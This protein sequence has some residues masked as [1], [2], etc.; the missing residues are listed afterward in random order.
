MAAAL[1]HARR[2]S[3]SVG[4]NSLA[5]ASGGYC[6]A[7]GGIYPQSY[8]FLLAANFAALECA[9][10]SLRS[11]DAAGLENAPPARFIE[12]HCNCD[13]DYRPTIAFRST[14]G[15]FSHPFLRDFCAAGALVV[16]GRLSAQCGPL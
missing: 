1:S 5:P 8:L 6:A 13:R 11:G 14:H 9:E 2:V 10:I 16:D 12:C 4:R 15:R 7:G 3:L